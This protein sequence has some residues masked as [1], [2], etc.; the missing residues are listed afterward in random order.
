MLSMRNKKNYHQILPLI[1]SSGTMKVYY[2]YDF[3]FASRMRSILEGKNLYKDSR[4][5]R[6]KIDLFRALF[7]NDP[8]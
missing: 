7:Q 3:L 8:A 6:L 1:Q 4:F 5:F 2:F